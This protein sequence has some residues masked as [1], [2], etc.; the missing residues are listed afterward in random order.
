MKKVL[1]GM[2]FLG[3]IVFSGISLQAQEIAGPE[4]EGCTPSI[5][6]EGEVITV[7]VCS[8]KTNFWGFID[9]IDCNAESNTSCSFTN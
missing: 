5:V 2:A 8:R 6:T 3:A 4:G 7:T 9:G 1:F